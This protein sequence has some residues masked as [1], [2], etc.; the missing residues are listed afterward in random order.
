MRNLKIIG[1]VSIFMIFLNSCKDLRKE[2]YSNGQEKT[3]TEYKNGKKDGTSRTYFENGTIWS[4][5]FYKEDKFVWK[6]EYSK[7]GNLDWET[8]CSN[9]KEN[10]IAIHYFPNGNVYKRAEYNFLTEKQNGFYKEYY[11]D[12][13]IHTEAFFVNDVQ[14]GESR[15]YY[16][17]EKL[18]MIAFKSDALV[19]YYIEY[20]EE[21]KVV[22]KYRRMVVELESELFIEGEPYKATVKIMGPKSDSLHCYYFLHGRNATKYPIREIEVDLKEMTFKI[23]TPPLKTGEYAIQIPLWDINEKQGYKTHYEPFKIIPK[24]SL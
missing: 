1:L 6:K 23:E 20:N 15:Y 13:T 11:S 21:G 12:G 14:T 17:N 7:G 24:P 5:A 9:G 16:P 22:E 19:D 3:V 8:D 2:Y 4:E 10:A 18:K